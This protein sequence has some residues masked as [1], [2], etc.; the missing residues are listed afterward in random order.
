M[1]YDQWR[2]A[3]PYDDEP[4]VLEEAD[5]FLRRYKPTQDELKDR[6]QEAYQLINDLLEYIEENV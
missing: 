3:S 6:F 5:K 1:S 2:T 4:D